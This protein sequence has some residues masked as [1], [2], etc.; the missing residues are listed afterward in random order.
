M[1]MYI[2][3]KH[4][5]L[6]FCNLNTTLL[7][8][9]KIYTY[10]TALSFYPCVLYYCLMYILRTANIIPSAGILPELQ[11]DM[12]QSGEEGNQLAVGRPAKIY[13]NTYMYMICTIM[14]SS[15]TIYNM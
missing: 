11:E 14:L 3:K 6:L 10:Y 4:I 9:N 15:F 13:K 12:L 7:Y 8:C 5:Y 1:Y 2:E